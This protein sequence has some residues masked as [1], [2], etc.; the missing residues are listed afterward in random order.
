MNGAPDASRAIRSH[1]SDLQ[2]T[3]MR[4][5]V[6]PLHRWRL[7]AV[8]TQARQRFIVGS[9]GALMAVVALGLL[10][11]RPVLSVSPPQASAVTMVFEPALPPPSASQP[12][13]AMAPPPPEMQPPARPIAAAKAPASPPAPTVSPPPVPA[14]ATSAPTASVPA[15][16]APS[17]A[18]TPAAPLKSAPA[19]PS[20]HASIAHP[21]R[22][23]PASPPRLEPPTPTASPPTPTVD[24]PPSSRAPLSAK[25]AEAA[26]ARASP[27]EI[28]A[29]QA[30][31][32]QAVRTAL[33]YPAS[34]RM[35]GQGGE[36]RVGFDFIDGRVS[37]LALASSSGFPL[38]DRAALATVAAAIFPAPP[39][40]YAHQTLHLSVVVAFDPEPPGVSLS[41]AEPGIWESDRN[42]GK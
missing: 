26:P 39:P 3:T 15:R 1:A 31:S 19:L 9:G 16:S 36:V 28:A 20:H 18:P 25:L 4:L 27:S 5:V 24:S 22:P 12:S 14:P 8:P 30:Q 32:R 13:P 35:A 10:A 34:A 33:I 11:I 6:E 38:L 37:G 41:V 2:P 40:A 17:A 29:F 42:P 21:A 23:G 7:H